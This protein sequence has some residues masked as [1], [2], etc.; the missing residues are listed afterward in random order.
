M[1]SLDPVPLAPV[2]LS[3]TS[4]P[5]PA[6][7]LGGVDILPAVD[8]IDITIDAAGAR[9]LLDL[10]VDLEFDFPIARV[11]M[12]EDR[13]EGLTAGELEE[14]A[15]SGGY[16]SSPWQALLSHLFNRRPGGG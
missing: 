7:V 13:L 8:R 10:R 6:I 16:A 9:C 1:E 15:M 5:R 4:V 3:I 2:L 12:A 11:E 14:A